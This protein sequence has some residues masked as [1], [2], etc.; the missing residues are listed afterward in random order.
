MGPATPRQV[1]DDGELRR[2]ERAAGVS[3]IQRELR[4]L[5]VRDAGGRPLQKTGVFDARTEQAVR[6]FQRAQGD[7]VTGRVD[8]RTQRAIE[9]A[10]AGSRGRPDRR[11]AMDVPGPSTNLAERLAPEDL[12]LLSGLWSG[13]EALDRGRGRTPDE[14]SERLTWSLLAEAK[15]RGISRADHVVLSIASGNVQAGDNVFVVQGGLGDPGNRVAWVKSGGAVRQPLD[16]SLERILAASVQPAQMAQTLEQVRDPA[17]VSS[18][19]R[20][21]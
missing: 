6:E 9:D 2:L 13:V 11:A 8:A 3:E 10:P 12:R 16:A 5:D 18:I 19:H 14:L 17:P 4:R 1:G 20:G 7:A 15:S 21:F